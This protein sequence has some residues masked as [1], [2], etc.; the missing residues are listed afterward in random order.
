MEIK[1]HSFFVLTLPS[2]CMRKYFTTVFNL[3][4]FILVYVVNI[5]FVCDGE[6]YLLTYLFADT[7][8]TRQNGKTEGLTNKENFNIKEKAN[9]IKYKDKTG[10]GS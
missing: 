9:F 6:I 8:C 7:T 5:R 10:C 1:L 2:H 3:I 4:E